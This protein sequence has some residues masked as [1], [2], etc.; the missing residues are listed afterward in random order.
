MSQTTPN[1]GATRKAAIRK[2]CED[3][4]NERW[5]R[6]SDIPPDPFESVLLYIPDN[7]PYPTVHEGYRTEDGSFVFSIAYNGGGKVT[8][9]RHKPEPPEEP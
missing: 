3:K 5:T 6:V 2:L 9:W 4:L 1:L 7:A 8:H